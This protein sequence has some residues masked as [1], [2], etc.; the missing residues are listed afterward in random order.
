MFL[1]SG[2]RYVGELLELNQGCQEPFGGSR[3]KVGFH[4][5]R[6]SGK[7]PHLALRGESPGYSRVAA[8]NLGFLSSYDGDLKEPLLFLRKVQSACELRG[9]SLDSSP[10]RA[11][12]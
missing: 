7:S 6:R 3:G 12:A 5:R 1:S 10:V 9:V 2:D 8:R 4:W 11:G